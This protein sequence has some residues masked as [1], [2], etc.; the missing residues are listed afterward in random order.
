[1]QLKRTEP[2]VRA[3]WLVAALTAD[4]VTKGHLVEPDQGHAQARHDA[5]APL[6]TGRATSTAGC[7]PAPTGSVTIIRLR[8]G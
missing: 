8:H 6:I 3:G 2:E 1:V 7:M 5:G 4:Q